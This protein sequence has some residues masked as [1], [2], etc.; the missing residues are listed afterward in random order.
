APSRPADAALVTCRGAL[1]SFPPGG[2]PA[3][4]PPGSGTVTIHPD[5]PAERPPTPTPATP[6]ALPP[7]IGRFEVI[8]YLGEGTFGRVYEAHDPVLKRTVAL[9]VAKP[10]QLTGE[11]RVRRFQREAQ[12][13]A[14]RL[15]PHV[16]P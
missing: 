1:L 2:T 11:G 13:A 5:Q 9:K 16:V 15:R 4:A 10:E 12:A 6:T 7:R 3:A 14:R 8:R